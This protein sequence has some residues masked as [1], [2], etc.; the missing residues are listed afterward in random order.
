[1][2]HRHWRFIPGHEAVVLGFC[3]LDPLPRRQRSQ[4]EHA[5]WRLNCGT[6]TGSGAG[7]PRSARPRSAR[8]LYRPGG[9]ATST[10]RVSCGG[11]R[12]G[13]GRCACA[14]SRG[15][16]SAVAE[17][18]CSGRLGVDS[19]RF[20]CTTQSEGCFPGLRGSIV[21]PHSGPPDASGC[22]VARGACGVRAPEG[23]V[24][25][26][27]GGQ[28]SSATTTTSPVSPTA[29]RWRCYRAMR[30]GAGRG[31]GRLPD[32]CRAPETLS[33]QAAIRRWQLPHRTPRAPWCLCHCRV[34]R[35]RALRLNDQAA[36]Q[37]PTAQRCNAFVRAVQHGMRS[38]IDFQL[39]F[40]SRHVLLTA[41]TALAS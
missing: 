35:P 30:V 29:P 7:W 27:H 36:R 39:L 21:W 12:C 23:L 9:A 17:V 38:G 18:L 31:R 2:S 11:R 19:H 13:A 8:P 41:H 28:C 33:G 26:R 37:C 25:K 24:A 4:L 16:G 14:G 6:G 10:R 32:P 1:M 22:L 3:R 15:L 34:R 20:R 40:R 5:R